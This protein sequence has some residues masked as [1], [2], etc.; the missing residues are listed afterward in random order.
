MGD[1]CVTI[2]NISTIR[3]DAILMTGESLQAIHL[4]NLSL[5]DAMKWLET[6]WK[7]KKRHELRKKNDEFLEYLAWLWRFCVGE[8]LEPRLRDH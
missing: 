5:G 7:A 3:S 8:I 4:S 6:E 1:S 2:V